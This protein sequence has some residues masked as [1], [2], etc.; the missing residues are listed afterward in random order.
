MDNKKKVDSNC[1]KN[2]NENE[3]FEQLLDLM[4]ENNLE[5][6]PSM[7]NFPP[8]E[9]NV[10]LGKFLDLFMNLNEKVSWEEIFCDFSSFR[11]F[12]SETIPLDTRLNTCGEISNLK[13]NILLCM[14]L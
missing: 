2:E 13:N 3:N 1:K 11:K 14:A 12:W 5:L 10:T 8:D 6:N 7:E 4:K 9:L